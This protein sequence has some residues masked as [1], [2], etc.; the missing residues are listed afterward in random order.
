MSESPVSP[1]PPPGSPPPPFAP[2][3]SRA[4]A[5]PSLAG[6]TGPRPASSRT[7]GES[8]DD[9]KGRVFPCEGCGADLKFHIGQQQMKCPYC[10]YEKAL[11]IG[12]EA[13]IVE[14]DYLETLAKLRELRQGAPPGAG[15]ASTDQHEVRCESC[16]GNVLF[17]GTLTSSECPY[18]GTPI[19]R[20]K[21]HDASERI[22]VD[23]VLPFLV[24]KKQAQQNLTAWV[25]SRWFAPNEFR[26]RGV[27]GKFN[28]VYLPYWTYDALTS[29]SYVG[30]RGE[31][32]Y[33]EVGTGD[34]KRRERRTRWYPASGRFQRFFDDVLVIG[35]AG[36]NQ[37]LVLALEPWPLEKLIP[38]TPEVLSGFLARTYDIEL[39]EGFQEAK[40]RIEE[41]IEQDVRGRI[42]GDEQ[43]I[44]SI[45]SRFGALRY[46][47][48]LLPVWLLAYR[49]HG[50][51]Y[52]VMINA[53]TGEVQGER[54]YSWVKITLAILAAIIAVAAIVM[55]SQS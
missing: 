16:G 36:M 14:Q 48:L 8:I 50:K 45:H 25:Q 17:T 35:S 39:D 2:H 9:G 38:Y 3:G 31:H 51:T 47:H 5:A 7:V 53:G 6:G 44:T 55:L 18:C 10:G 33:V 21:V 54:P 26:Q 49:F 42:G 11:E 40:R 13:A 20:D 1:P 37:N 34:N 15:D 27:K 46:K 4:E 30:Q 52:Q 22:P 43:R 28:G 32:Y 12:E 41:A 24:E 23:G 19:Q 29:N